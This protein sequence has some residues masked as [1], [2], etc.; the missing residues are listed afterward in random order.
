MVIK[1]DLPFL[2]NTTS[3]HN[4]VCEMRGRAI[5][6]LKNVGRIW[7]PHETHIAHGQWTTHMGTIRS[8]WTKTVWAPYGLLI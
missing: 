5:F 4:T 2:L 3:H 6:L 8:R 1:N 7:D